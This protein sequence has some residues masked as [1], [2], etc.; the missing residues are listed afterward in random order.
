MDF[1]EPFRISRYVV[2]HAEA[3]GLAPQLNSRDF[4]V[5]TSLDGETWTTVGSQVGNTSAVTDVSITP[6]EAQY[7]RVTVTNAGIDGIVR[8]ADIEVYGAH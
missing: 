8:I 7:V 6:V 4:I 3:G 1:K 2:R 5:E